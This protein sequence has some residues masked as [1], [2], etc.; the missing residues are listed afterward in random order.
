[1]A[2][3]PSPVIFDLEKPFMDEVDALLAKYG[4]CINVITRRYIPFEH[5]YANSFAYIADIVSEGDVI[6][7]ELLQAY[8]D[9]L[10]YVE[11]LGFAGS[12][13]VFTP[14]LL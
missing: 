1:M 8:E 9:G 4:D 11:S 10:Q 6:R 2:S 7:Q 5:Y 14:K 13:A 3:A 12:F